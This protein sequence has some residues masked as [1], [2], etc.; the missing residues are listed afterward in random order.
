VAHGIRHLEHVDVSIFKD[1]LSRLINGG[2]GHWC[3]PAELPP[4]YLAQMCSEEKAIVRNRRT[5]QLKEEWVLVSSAAPNYYWDCEVYA[6]AAA[7]M[8]HVASMRPGARPTVYV[9][10][11][12]DGG[13]APAPKPRGRED[14]PFR[15][16]SG[17]WMT[18]R[19]NWLRR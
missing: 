17:P 19:S 11:A 7:D 1:R 14:S 6:A 18:R 15:R 10:H 2:A 4:D 8:A 13:P 9:P 12:A 3:L 5:L 16:S